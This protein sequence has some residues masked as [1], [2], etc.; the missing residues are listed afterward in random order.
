[1]AA[2]QSGNLISAAL[3]TGDDAMAVLLTPYPATRI[4]RRETD[5]PPLQAVT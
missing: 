2:S 5:S 3:A 4:T 1:M